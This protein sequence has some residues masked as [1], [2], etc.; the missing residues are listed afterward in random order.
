MLLTE[1]RVLI[2]WGTLNFGLNKLSATPC[3]NA[4][5]LFFVMSSDN[6]MSLSVYYINLIPEHT[7][8]R[9]LN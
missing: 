6:S 8:K 2:E 1:I 7:V 4:Q 3:P 5:F 9:A